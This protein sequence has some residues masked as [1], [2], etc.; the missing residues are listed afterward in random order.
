MAKRTYENGE[1]RVL[2]DSSYCIHSARCIRNGAGVFDPGR[3]PWVDMDQADTDTIV[4]AIERCPTGAL[5]Y[6]RIDGQSSEKPDVPTNVV[7]YPNGPLFVRGQVEVRDRHGE[8]FVAS[9]R[10]ALCRCGLSGNQPF[11]DLS[12][13]DSAF[14]DKA[15]APAHDRESAM[16]PSEIS[17]NEL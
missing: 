16:N 15:Q 7:P 11:C 13:R 2:W 6:E 1:V 9:P 5:R 14:R 17:P 10:V 8:M 3:R 12:H 4:Y